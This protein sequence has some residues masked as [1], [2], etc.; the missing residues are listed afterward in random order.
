[1]VTLFGVGGA[2]KTRL[3]LE[4]AAQMQDRFRRGVRVVNL[5]NM[6]TAPDFDVLVEVVMRELDVP[7]QRPTGRMRTLVE[8]LNR[9]PAVL[10]VLDNCEHI[11]GLVRRLVSEILEWTGDSV[12]IVATSRERLQLPG[13]VLVKVPP[14][15]V[16]HLD[17]PVTR[18]RDYDA[19]VLLHERAKAGVPGFS[20]N[21]ADW[22]HLVRVLH[23]VEGIPLFIEAVAF[24][25][26]AMPPK[27]LADKLD[28]LF[29]GLPL[30][31]GRNGQTNHD[32]P[33]TLLTWSYERC[34]E[35]EQL[36]WSRLSVFPGPMDWDAALHVCAGDALPA[37]RIDDAITGLV[38]KSVL[39]WE[40]PTRGRLRML[41]VYRDFG[42]KQLTSQNATD[43]MWRRYLDHYSTRLAT[44]AD[45]FTGAAEVE[46]LRAV[47]ADIV[48]FRTAF[49]SLVE[50]PGQA[51]AALKMA[52]D[53]GRTRW[54]IYANGVAEEQL[55]LRR[56]LEATS[57]S[58][59]PLR[60]AAMAMDVWGSVLQGADPEQTG[61][62]LAQAADMVS[63]GP[64][65]IPM[66][67][68][69]G[70]YV[71]ISLGRRDGL[72][73]L[74]NAQAQFAAAGPAFAGD[75]H[76]A[77]LLLTVASVTAQDQDKEDA[78]AD[79]R[80]F[81][82]AVDRVGGPW[83]RV[84]AD[85]CRSVWEVR[86]G[87]PEKAV[88]YLQGGAAVQEGMD[89]RWTRLWATEALGGA[90]PTPPPTP[91][92]RR[93]SAI[94]A[95]RD[96]P[97]THRSPHLRPRRL[98]RT[99]RDRGASSSCPPRRGGVRPHLPRGGGGHRGRLRRYASRSPVE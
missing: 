50:I 44:L 30:R 43:A 84:W 75:A 49:T 14:L 22:P 97:A 61:R 62:L 87:D 3:A 91:R 25:L 28:D 26:L 17:T 16:P 56:A 88:E 73:L 78:R 6:P 40:T 58:S 23:R 37:H 33:F 65:A 18:W 47:E 12:R 81:H 89:D 20:I 52:V 21:A 70:A 76:M 2:G 46:L 72:D 36:L 5:L 68:A 57:E 4:L 29:D 85:W 83:G 63:D 39:D 55:W 82:D 93:R 60:A 69:R 77:E 15:A 92:G 86:W 45:G 51:L 31:R 59:S 80:R 8:W 27:L 48:H 74:R 94:G 96:D 95:C 42:A 35:D 64:E 7:D 11:V 24:R 32:T 41:E 66:T 34:T 10:L 54:P 67:F 1:M 38:D 79:V 53:L 98:Q 9:R 90:G 71:A 13:E 19:A 99:A